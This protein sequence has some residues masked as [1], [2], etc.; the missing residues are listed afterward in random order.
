MEIPLPESAPNCAGDDEREDLSRIR[1]F[2]RIER[3]QHIAARLK[4]EVCVGIPA[5]PSVHV[6][7]SDGNFAA[8]AEGRDK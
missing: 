7:G 8:I 4:I 1:E 6:F 3:P 2:A 5:R